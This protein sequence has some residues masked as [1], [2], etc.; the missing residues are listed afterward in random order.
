MGR[1]YQH[2]QSWTYGKYRGKVILELRISTEQYSVVM[3]Y[4]IRPLMLMLFTLFW[5]FSV[6][7]QEMRI[8]N[9]KQ[10]KKGLFGKKHYDTDKSQAILDLYTEEKGFIFKAN[11]K[12]EVTAAD[13]EG[14]ISLLLPNKTEYIKINHPKFGELTWKVP[15]KEKRVKKKRHYQAELITVDP[16]KAN[17]IDRQW[18]VFYV[19]PENAILHVD[20]TLQ[21][22]RNGK[23]QVYLSVGKHTCKIE[24]PFYEPW[25][26]EVCIYDTCRSNVEVAL[27]PAY[28]YLTVK[29][30]LEGCKILLDGDTIGDTQ[31]ISNK[32]MAGRYR[33]TIVRK[34]L[35]YYNEW[36]NILPAEKKIINIHPEDMRPMSIP[37]TM[38]MAQL[39]EQAPTKLPFI[40]QP[41]PT[42]KVCGMLNIES[43]VV[44][45]EIY[46]D[47]KLAGK[48]P[49]IIP[50][51]I[52]F[53]SHE[54]TL[55]KKGYK[56]IKQTIFIRGNETNKLSLNMKSKK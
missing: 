23:T 51:I 16:D 18:A 34:S 43:N 19:Q 55:K 45:A 48:T 42:P 21:S 49:A 12:A 50:D 33:L 11:G 44:D 37:P 24:A 6:N 28:S 36:V 35:C 9:F 56:D 32:L 46:I 40:E 39:V 30:P 22:I 17:K 3:K 27:Q 5:T 53:Q 4:G 29:T 1:E 31:T 13:G 7:G 41:V 26:G 54:V 52:A 25:E 10:L 14:F 8:E 20:S 15:L 47:G 2:H 38:T